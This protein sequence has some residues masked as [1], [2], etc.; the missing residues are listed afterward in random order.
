MGHVDVE[1]E[2]MRSMF[3]QIYNNMW[4]ER[5]IENLEDREEWKKYKTNTT[6]LLSKNSHKTKKLL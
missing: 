5:D 1:S 3:K 4:W 2:L 6:F